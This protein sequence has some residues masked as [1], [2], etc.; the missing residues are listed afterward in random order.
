MK[1]M[2]I[3]IDHKEDCS[4]CVFCEEAI[5]CSLKDGDLCYSKDFEKRYCPIDDKE[6]PITEKVTIVER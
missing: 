2:I 1:M 3:K 4:N 6:I 5:Y